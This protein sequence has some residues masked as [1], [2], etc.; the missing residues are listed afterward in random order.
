[1]GSGEGDARLIDSYEQAFLAIAREAGEDVS[2]IDH[3]NQLVY[4]SL[5]EFAIRAVREMRET[6]EEDPEHCCCCP[7]HCKRTK[8]DDPETAPVDPQ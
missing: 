3:P 4:P 5:P 6:Y 7:D 1:M 2:G 8:E